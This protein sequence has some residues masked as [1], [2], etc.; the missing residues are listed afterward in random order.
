MGNVAT[1]LSTPPCTNFLGSLLTPLSSSCAPVSQTLISLAP[2]VHS[3]TEGASN[4]SE[5]QDQSLPAVTSPPGIAIENPHLNPQKV[6]EADP[7][8]SRK[9]F[10]R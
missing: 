9:E 2:E 4:S 5:V 8:C 10:K 3:V 7:Q 1:Q 6:K